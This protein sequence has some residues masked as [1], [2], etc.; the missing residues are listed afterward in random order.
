MVP[1]H[2]LP[3]LHETIKDQTPPAYP[4]L[5]AVYK[6]MVPALIKQATEDPDYHIVRPL[7]TPFKPASAT[8]AD[9]VIAPVQTG[10]TYWVEACA[11][12]DLAEEDVTG[13]VHNGKTYAIYRLL[14]DQFYASDGICTHEKA[15]LAGGLII[16]GCIECPR[17][18]GRFDVTTGAAVRAP[19]RKP[20]RTYP[21]ERRGNKVV[22]NIPDEIEPVVQANGQMP[23]N[24]DV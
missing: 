16:N 1:Y 18:N 21:A 13:F 7:P 2:A 23:S 20:L 17:H 5:W 11:V 12:D 14:G 3:R 6:E 4:S 22:I 9:A 8:A 19:A 15:E 24:K 10:T